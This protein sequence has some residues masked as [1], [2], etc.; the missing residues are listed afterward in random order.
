MYHFSVH[1]FYKKNWWKLWRGWDSTQKIPKTMNIND[2][3][4]IIFD[5]RF[6]WLIIVCLGTKQI[7]FEIKLK[8]WLNTYFLMD[9][10][11]TDVAMRK[12]CPTPLGIKLH[13]M[14]RYWMNAMQVK[15]LGSWN[16]MQIQATMWKFYLFLANAAA[17]AK[18][19]SQIIYLRWQ[20]IIHN[21]WRIHFIC[22]IF[23]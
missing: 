7:N 10:S 6:F 4:E 8:N 23:A 20:N 12:K 11:H 19:Q 9:N 16:Q 21:T 13:K 18:P 14:E 22:L 2:N 17:F 15:N 5:D 3:S 1:V